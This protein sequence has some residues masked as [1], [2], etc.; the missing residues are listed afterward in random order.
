[1]AIPKRTRKKTVRARARTGAG[2]APLEKGFS[3]AV[4]SYFH[5]EIDKKEA[6]DIMKRYVKQAYNKDDTKAIL[7]NPEY[8]FC[9]MSHYVA[10]AYWIL[11]EMDKSQLA[12][13]GKSNADYEA[14]LKRYCDDMIATGNKILAEKKVEAQEAGN[15]ISLSPMQKLER[16]IARTIIADIDDLED[17]WIE[18][19]KAVL[20]IYVSFQRHALPPSATTAITGI[21]SGWLLDYGDAYHKRCEQAVEGYSHLTRSELKRRLD[22]CEKMLADIERIKL[23]GKAKRSVRKSKPKAAD[24]QIARMQYKKE[25]NDYKIVSINPVLVIGAMR[26]LTFNVKT[27]RLTE[28]VAV[29]GSTGFTVSGSTIKGFDMGLSR[30]QSLRKPDVFLPIALKKTPKQI[31]VEW[32]ALTTKA[33]DANGRIN[34]DTIILRVFDK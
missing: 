8:K 14:G 34:K 10:T 24:K 11:C 3:P 25:D 23:S 22:E 16:K 26:L 4:L 1:M 18:G 21:I 2:A 19:E 20:D 17:K 28:L 29:E 6:S 7:A 5:L 32:K 13:S 31:D 27:K 12:W 9:S 15:V 33:Y 30:S